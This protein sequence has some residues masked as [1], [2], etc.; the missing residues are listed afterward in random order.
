VAEIFK[1]TF[2]DLLLNLGG[3]KST[4]IE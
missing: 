3:L 4:S 1:A 2:F